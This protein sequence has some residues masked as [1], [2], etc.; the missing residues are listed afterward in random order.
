MSRATSDPAPLAPEG[1]LTGSALLG[2]LRGL[3]ELASAP[4]PAARRL[5]AARSSGGAPVRVLAA[6]EEASGNPEA[7]KLGCPTPPR[8]ILPG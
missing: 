7:Q 8:P 1:S 3:I 4:E 6:L 5:L 2:A